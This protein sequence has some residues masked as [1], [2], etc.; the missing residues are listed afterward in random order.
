[1]VIP[2]V[3]Q[4]IGSLTPDDGDDDYAEDGDAGDAMAGI[5]G[6]SRGR[7]ALCKHLLVHWHSGKTG[8]EDLKL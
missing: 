5:T 1:M 3:L 8:P 7:L 6:S 2:P 4:C